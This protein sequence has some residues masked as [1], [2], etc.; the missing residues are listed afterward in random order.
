M[1]PVEQAFLA[2]IAVQP[3]DDAPRL[4]FADWLE[5][6]EQGERAE[7]IRVQ[8]ELATYPQEVEWLQ[9]MPVEQWSGDE[10][11]GKLLRRLDPLVRYE[12]E[13][14]IDGR[15]AFA[16]LRDFLAKH[17]QDV[18]ICLKC[19]RGFISSITLSC[20]I[21][22]QH[23][24][25]IIQA[26]PMLE[27]VRLSDKEV[28]HSYLNDQ[29]WMW[30]HETVPMVPHPQLSEMNRLPDG[31]FRRLKGGRGSVPMCK[32]YDSQEEGTVDLLQACLTFARDQLAQRKE[33]R[34]GVIALNAL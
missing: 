25:D 3:Q 23:A 11:T 26:V 16:A 8:C 7:F 10:E 5:E 20:N 1:N 2:D 12:R 19:R 31:L 21:F 28:G 30:F 15:L 29:R 9:Q 22:L 18:S 13:M 14:L 33:P 17:G 6:H 32:W 4:I 34:P 27:E 24:A